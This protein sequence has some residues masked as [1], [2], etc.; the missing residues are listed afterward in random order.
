[1]QNIYNHIY[2]DDQHSSRKIW[3]QNIVFR[4]NH[5]GIIIVQR[6]HN[7]C[8]I[9]IT[10]S[11]LFW[12]LNIRIRFYQFSFQQTSFHL[13]T[14]FSLEVDMIEIII[15]NVILKAFNM[16]VNMCTLKW[17]EYSDHLWKLMQD[18]MITNK[19]TDVTIVC[20]DKKQIQAHRHILSACSP[21]LRELFMIDEKLVKINSHQTI[22]D[23]N[24]SS[25]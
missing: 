2:W 21:V 17:K 14:F 10:Y 8:K 4:G 12:Y 22:L 5:G 3:R 1:M 15:N 16:D 6:N 20:D 18:L 9:N 13:G 7:K 25:K 19:F 24:T 23:I 11:F